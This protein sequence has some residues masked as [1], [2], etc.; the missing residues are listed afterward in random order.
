MGLVLLYILDLMGEAADYSGDI[1]NS[2]HHRMY[3]AEV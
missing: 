1:A 2:V 3:G